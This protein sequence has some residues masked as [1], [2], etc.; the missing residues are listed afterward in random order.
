MSLSALLRGLEDQFDKLEA[1]LQLLDDAM[2]R[3]DASLAS[4]S[5]EL[6]GLTE[7]VA[8]LPSKGFWLAAIAAEF[9]VM[10]GAILFDEELKALMG[11]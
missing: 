9:V 5:A 1:A 2:T 11:I 6:D 10:S 4:F 8:R 3:L 7:R